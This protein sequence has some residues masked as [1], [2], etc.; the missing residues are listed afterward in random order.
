MGGVLRPSARTIGKAPLKQHL[1]PAPSLAGETNKPS[2]P[3]MTNV[4]RARHRWTRTTHSRRSLL[5]GTSVRPARRFALMIVP[6]GTS[7]K[8]AHG[9]VWIN[10]SVAEIRR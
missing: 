4:Q 3:T 7:Y 6:L 8:Q 1:R 2:K 9:A 10:I 5:Q